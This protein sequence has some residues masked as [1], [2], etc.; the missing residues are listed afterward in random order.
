[1]RPE[2]FR[3]SLS[4]IVK[5]HVV[6]NVGGNAVRGARKVM[7]WCES[8]R[9]TKEGYSRVGPLLDNNICVKEVLQVDLSGEVRLPGNFHTFSTNVQ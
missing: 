8:R 2:P 4:G 9:I 6:G 3:R 1:M 7:R 5:S